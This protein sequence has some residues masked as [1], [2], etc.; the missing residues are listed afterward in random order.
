[1]IDRLKAKVKRIRDRCY[2]CFGNTELI[3]HDLIPIRSSFS[4]IIC[5]FDLPSDRDITHYNIADIVIMSI[6]GVFLCLYR[7]RIAVD[8]LIKILGCSRIINFCNTEQI[9]K[10]RKLPHHRSRPAGLVIYDIIGKLIP[11]Y[12]TVPF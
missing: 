11:I 3:C 8:C 9:C 2:T 7:S 10:L 4:Y 12:T 6:K 1:M 5:N